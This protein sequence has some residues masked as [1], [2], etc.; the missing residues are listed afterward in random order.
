MSR[1]R[2]TPTGSLFS[3]DVLAD[4]WV[5]H[6]CLMVGTEVEAKAHSIVHGHEV[7][8]VSEAVA[9]GRIELVEQP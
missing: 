6:R 9:G 8:R 1:R 5:C 4:A 7:E 3:D 2:T